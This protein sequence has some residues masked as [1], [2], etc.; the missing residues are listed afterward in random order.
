MDADRRQASNVPDGQITDLPVQPHLQKYS[1]SRFTQIKF[2]IPRRPVPS[3][4]R[5][6]IVTDVGRGMRWQLKE[7]RSSIPMRWIIDFSPSA[8]T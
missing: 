2:Y 4:G 1:A 5:F 6:A 7:D 8:R 3:E